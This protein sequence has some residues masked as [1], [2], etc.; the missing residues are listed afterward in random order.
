MVRCVECGAALKDMLE[1]E[2]PQYD[3][4]KGEEPL[5]PPG[6]Y[7]PIADGVASETVSGLMAQFHQAG[8]PIKVEAYGYAMRLSARSEEMAAA[9][10]ILVREGVLPDVPEG[11]HRAVAAEG[12]PCP[13][14]G[15][16]VPPGTLECPDCGLQ[17]GSEEAEQE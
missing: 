13:A 1:D 11:A 17:L 2:E 8:I 14:C 7:E 6:E 5:L 4:P 9:R 3:P 12:G 16:E 10:E 15:T